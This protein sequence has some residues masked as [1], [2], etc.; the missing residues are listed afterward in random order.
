M[1]VDEVLCLAE[2]VLGAEPD[3]LD[4]WMLASELLDLRGLP[5]TRRS[6]RGPEPE[7]RVVALGQGLEVHRIA[8]RN[9]GHVEIRDVGGRRSL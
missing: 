2:R 1:S 8:G 3:D 7:Q 4:L 6:V 5:V 9:R